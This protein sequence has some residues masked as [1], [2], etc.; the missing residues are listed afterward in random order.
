MHVCVRLS[1]F[2]CVWGMRARARAYVRAYLCGC[3]PVRVSLCGLVCLY[4]CV[5]ECECE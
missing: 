5:S 4:V 3:A 2:A 1:V